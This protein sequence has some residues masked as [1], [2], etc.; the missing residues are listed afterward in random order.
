MLDRFERA[1]VINLPER[2]DRRRETEAQLERIGSKDLVQFHSATRPDNK[3][4]FNSI[5]EHGCYL[6]H[7]AVWKGAVG[8]KS[9][10]VM[11]DDVQFVPDYTAR[12]SLIDQLPSNWE[13]FYLGHMQLPELKREWAETGI[14]AIGPDVEFIGLHCYA[15]NGR[16]LP[17][18]ICSAET[19]LSREHGHPDGGR[20]PVDGALNIARRQLGL[21]TYAAIPPL[22]N[23]RASRT[24]IGPLRWFDRTPALGGAVAF[25]RYLKNQVRHSLGAPGR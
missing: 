11:E 22:A 15:I 20:M 17:R 8:A 24:D 21:V 12:A 25:A 1:Y 13:V 19:F 10:L 2:K 9:I 5:G 23:Q 18:L 16:A 3:G 6:S 14:V 7:L 4:G